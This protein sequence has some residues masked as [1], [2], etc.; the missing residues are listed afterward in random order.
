MPQIIPTS[1]P[2]VFEVLASVTVLQRQA[3]IRPQNPPPGLAGFLFDIPEEERMRLE[4]IITDFYLEDKTAV[5]DGIGLRPETFTVRGLVAELVST[6]QL[7]PGQS[8]PPPPVLPINALQTP[9]PT[10]AQAQGLV[11]VGS[12]SESLAPGPAQ[13]SAVSESLAISETAASAVASGTSADLVA[14]LGLDP[15]YADD[16][17][18]SRVVAAANSSSA[19]PAADVG[20]RDSI[21]HPCSRAGARPATREPL[22][23]V[24]VEG[25]RSAGP[26]PAVSRVGLHLPAL[27]RAPAL[28]RRNPV[29]LSRKHGD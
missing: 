13:P 24:P 12:L 14:Q 7:T 2:S 4:S 20:R 19:V 18:A 16:V 29:G 5:S 26:D 23:H 27:E 22:R 15:T 6:P 9:L 3:I 11:R 25:R 8:A 10:P 21:T 17:G 28:H 1:E